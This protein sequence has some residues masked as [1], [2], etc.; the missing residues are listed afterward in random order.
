M[1]ERILA[2][3]DLSDTARIATDRAANLTEALGAKLY[4]VHVGRD[5]AGVKTL[6]EKYGAEPVVETG[7]P[8]EVLIDKAA[9]L[10]ADLLVVGSV[11]MRGAK[12]FLLGSVPN[13]VS[14]HAPSDLLVVK[15]DPPPHEFGD[16][17]RLLVGTDGSPT[18]MKA[19]DAA[20]ELAKAL[21]IKPVIV[22]VF[23]PLSDH[24]RE[25]LR[26]DP[27]DAIAQWNADKSVRDVP[28]EFRW[29][30]AGAKQAEDV[31]DRAL[32]HASKCGV[33]AETRALE[34]NPAECLI[35]LA[36][37]ED[38]DLIVVGSVG[39]RGAKRFALGNV[40]HRIS[41]HAPTDVLI[42]KTA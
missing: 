10:D 42:L 35:A 9:E 31:L 1:Y 21:S 27:N 22:C 33:D 36:E 3:T 19:V 34:G 11:G 41:H 29:R 24:E 7:D 20:C 40:P 8:A 15:T 30:I 18:A 28:E 5:E 25:L 4:L 37:Q 13:K 6:A 23:E 32:D 12:R 17:T 2:G 26:A 14:H 16:Y 39:M 38:F